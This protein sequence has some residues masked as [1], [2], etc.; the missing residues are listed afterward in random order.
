MLA[1]EQAE[2]AAEEVI[3]IGGAGGA[4]GTASVELA[5]QRGARVIACVGDSAK[6]KVARDCGADEIVSSRSKS[7][8]EDLQKL[9]P[10]RYRCSYRSR[11]RWIF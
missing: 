10:R 5:R 2:L 7:L 3:L 4:V 6:E 1:L 11:R 9:A 8:Q